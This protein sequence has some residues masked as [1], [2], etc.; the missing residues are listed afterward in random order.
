VPLE[1]AEAAIATAR[2]FVDL[3]AELL[4]EPPPVSS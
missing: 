4:D 3:I 1:R 2:W